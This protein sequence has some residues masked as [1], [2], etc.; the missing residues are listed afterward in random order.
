MSNAVGRSRKRSSGNWLLDLASLRSLLPWE[1]P[2]VEWWGQKPEWSGFKEKNVRRR[3]GDRRQL[4]EVLLWKE[5]ETWGAGQK[6]MDGKREFCLKY[7]KIPACVY[8]CKIAHGGG[9]LIMQEEN[10]W[11]PD[12]KTMQWGNAKWLCRLAS[13]TEIQ[14]V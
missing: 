14:M 1:E 7:G 4:R 13:N 12:F 2:F 8:A 6:E 10:L 3:V 11:S 9:T 5:G